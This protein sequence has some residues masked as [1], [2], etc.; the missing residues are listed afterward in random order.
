LT[1]DIAETGEQPPTKTIAAKG[2]I[3]GRQQKSVVDNLQH[4]H[5]PPPQVAGNHP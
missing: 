2:E 5:E 1:L 3:A 4:L